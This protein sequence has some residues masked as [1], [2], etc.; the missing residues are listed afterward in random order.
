MN[1]GLNCERIVL[2]TVESAYSFI[3]KLADAVAESKGDIELDLRREA[4]SDFSRRTDALRLVLINLERLETHVKKGRRILND[5]RSLRRLLFEERSTST[6][7]V[8][9][10]VRNPFGDDQIAL[11]FGWR[12]RRALSS[13]HDHHP[14]GGTRIIPIP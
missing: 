11:P 5:L 3:V 10:K 14:S 1:V 12:R 13:I 4:G 2:D 9:T 7:E 8:V 6:P